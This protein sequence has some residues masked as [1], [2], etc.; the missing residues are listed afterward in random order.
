MS[1]KRRLIAIASIWIVTGTVVGGL[2]L[3]AIF[4]ELVMQQFT[5][6][7]HVHL[8]ELQ[9]LADISAAGAIL[10]RDL[11]DPRYDVPESGFYWEIQ[12]GRR[13]I[14]RS[15]SLAGPA[16]EV[17]VA[18][19]TDTSIKS[20]SITGPTGT[21][22]VLEQAKWIDT[23]GA[24]VRF[25][26]GTDKRHLDDIVH[27]F[28]SLV[29]YSLAAFA[30]LMIGASAFL[31]LYAMRPFDQLRRALGTVR[32]GQ[33]PT[34]GGA[35]P[36]EV[37]PLVDDLNVLL[38]ST[39]ELIR[40]A[41][42]QAGNVA[43]GLKT[44]LAILTDE[45]DRIHERGLDQSATTILDQCRKMQR[46]ID[47]QTT[48]ARAV[49]MRDTPGMVASVG[50]AATEVASALRRLYAMRAISIESEIPH[51]AAVACDAQDLNEMLANLAD[52]ACKNANS[53]V[54]IR[55]SEPSHTGRITIAVEDDGSGLPPEAYEIVFNVGERWDSQKPGS[56]LGLAIVRDLAKLYGGDVRLGKSDLG[57]LAAQLELPKAA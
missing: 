49:G 40:R 47:Y 56:G 33:S 14:A 19:P 39:A 53:R 32:S 23:A 2:L 13:T 5:D 29:G 17:P 21:L 52:N 34:L 37:Q 11:S 31:F 45:A 43:H 6:E 12:Q 3:S 28:D 35:F 25:I 57:G 42:I 8:D 50:K 54:R 9:R 36:T 20:Y 30:A 44:P 51:S 48:R 27:G 41:R 4:R 24:P 22:M 7:L 26:I 10:Q 15:K 1:L 18:A 46:H 55:L 38:K 16:L